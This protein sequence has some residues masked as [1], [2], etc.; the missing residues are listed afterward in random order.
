MA[1]RC[2]RFYTARIVRPLG[3]LGTTALLLLGAVVFVAVVARQFG[4]ALVG[5]D[6]TAQLLLVFMVFLAMTVTQSQ[7][8]HVRMEALI[9][10]LPPWAR[11]IT[12]LLSL[13]ICIGMSALILYGTTLEAWAAYRDGEYQ[14]GTVQFPLWPAKAAIAF[15]VL[16]FSIHLVLEFIALVRSPA[17]PPRPTAALGGSEASP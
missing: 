14:Y 6:E 15:G 16:V 7:G 9:T 10:Y 12:D 5:A 11:R 13:A 2:L 1:R 4:V 8:G 17:D 3:F